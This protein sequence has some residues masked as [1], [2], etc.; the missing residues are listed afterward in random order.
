MILLNEPLF[1]DKDIVDTSVDL[2]QTLEIDGYDPL[3]LGSMEGLV[4]KRDKHYVEDVHKKWH[5]ALREVRKN[6]LLHKY[7]LKVDKFVLSKDAAKFDA[8]HIPVESKVSEILRRIFKPVVAEVDQDVAPHLA[9]A[10]NF[11]FA[12]SQSLTRFSDLDTLLS[13]PEYSFSA[14]SS[15]TL[16]FS[17]DKTGPIGNMPVL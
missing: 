8:E 11:I 3:L 9:D 2:K 13:R 17:S 10:H 1:S 12:D 16:P 4:T 15:H 6:I 14:P 5:I 7:K